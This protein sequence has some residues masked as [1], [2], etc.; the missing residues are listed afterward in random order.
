[1]VFDCF[2]NKSTDQK[3]V[4]DLFLIFNKNIYV[5]DLVIQL[6]R[7]WATLSVV[8]LFVTMVRELCSRVLVLSLIVQSASVNNN[9][10]S[11][12][13]QWTQRRSV[14]AKWKLQSEDNCVEQTERMKGAFINFVSR[15]TV[16]FAHTPVYIFKLNW[17]DHGTLSRRYKLRA[18]VF[19]TPVN[20]WVLRLQLQE[21]KLVGPDM[22]GTYFT[23]FY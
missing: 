21:L 17:R 22:S 12:H 1:M 16:N 14:W 4:I 7:S 19:S 23:K 20:E 5:Y 10:V 6:Q 11:I 13:G 15:I 18:A 8:C 3:S 9:R 2:N